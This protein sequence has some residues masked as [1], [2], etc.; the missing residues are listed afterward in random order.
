MQEQVARF[1]G[2]ALAVRTDRGREFTSRA[3]MTWA[4][5]RGVRHILYQPGKTTKNAYFE[6]VNSK[7]HDECLNE[8]W[9]P[10]L[11]QARAE[12]ARWRATT[13]RAAQQLRQDVPGKFSAQHRQQPAA[14]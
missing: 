5:R 10:S 7:F 3:F 6:S 11:K 4:Q 8:H 12:I 1:R 2:Y 13:G 14:P 9:F